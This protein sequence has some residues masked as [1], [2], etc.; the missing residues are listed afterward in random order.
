MN[1][2]THFLP[3]PRTYILTAYYPWDFTF[4]LMLLILFLTKKNNMFYH[5]NWSNPTISVINISNFAI[6][7]ALKLLQY[8][9]LTR[10]L[11]IYDHL[12][13]K[14]VWMLQNNMLFDTWN[15]NYWIN[16]P[17]I[18]PIWDNTVHTK[19]VGLW[20]GILIHQ[21]NFLKNKLLIFFTQNQHTIVCFYRSCN[22]MAWFS[23]K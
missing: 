13:S 22:S 7:I 1:K 14:V 18:M 8:S 5:E 11:Y 9:H 17:C 2:H 6:Y 3:T 19:G 16:T 4:W 21:S 23:C 10:K 20:E 12:Q 15:G